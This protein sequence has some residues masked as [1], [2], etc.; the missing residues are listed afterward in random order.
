MN[1][2]D[3]KQFQQKIYA[4]LDEKLKASSWKSGA[5]EAHGL[6]TGLACRGITATEI[7]NRMHLFQFSEDD[8][9]ALLEGLF[10]LILRD[11]ESSIPTFNPLLGGDK[12]HIAVRVDEIAN[13]C[14]GFIQGFC[15]DGDSAILEQSA[16]VQEIIQDIMDISG[17]EVD[18]TDSVSHHLEEEEKAFAEVEEYLRV[19][20]Q[21]IFDE[22]SGFTK[23]AQISEQIH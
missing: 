22:T 11:L 18:L 10:E 4:E 20:I 17:M 13:W 23:N 19:G 8:D 7:G 2:I 9:T 21:I 14:G 16:E 1:P 3:P 15:H 5:S 6:L 12:E